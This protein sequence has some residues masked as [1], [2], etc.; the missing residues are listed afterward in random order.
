LSFRLGTFRSGDA[1]FANFLRRQ[2]SHGAAGHFA[3]A[4]RADC[5]SSESLYLVTEP[6]EQPTDF[7]IAALVEHHFQNRRTLLAALH[8]NVDRVNE[9]FR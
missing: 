5:D 2:R 8:A 1:E 9:P 4:D 7:A 3:E 6:R